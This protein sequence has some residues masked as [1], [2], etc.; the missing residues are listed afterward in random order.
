MFK[1]AIIHY[2][3]SESDQ[4]Q[5]AKE[6]ASFR[7]MAV[8]NYIK[9]LELNARQIDTLFNSIAEEIASRQ[10]SLEENKPT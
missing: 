1:Q 3:T 10:Q 6:L 5:I 7:C 9:S 4:K 8:T 2:P